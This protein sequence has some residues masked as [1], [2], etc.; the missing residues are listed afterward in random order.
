[1]PGVREMFPTEIA[2][3]GQV[4]SCSVEVLRR[5]LAP[6]VSCNFIYTPAKATLRINFQC[7]CLYLKKIHHKAPNNLRLFPKIK[8]KTRFL[9]IQIDIYEL[10]KSERWFSSL[11]M[12]R[13]C[14][15]SRKHLL[16]FDIFCRERAVKGL[17]TSNAFYNINAS[18]K[19]SPQR[20]TKQ[21]K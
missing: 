17:N 9:L 12:V 1:M 21:K 8:V 2:P 14:G 15:L 5:W 20:L 13:C 11:L 4:H 19:I 7:P 6:S 18:K 3:L 16:E 10:L